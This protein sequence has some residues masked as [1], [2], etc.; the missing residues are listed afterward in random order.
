MARVASGRR[1]PGRAS[2]AKDSESGSDRKGLVRSTAQSFIIELLLS[3]LNA[4]VAKLVDARDL[5]Y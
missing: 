3:S 5:Y 2:V 1:R 4:R